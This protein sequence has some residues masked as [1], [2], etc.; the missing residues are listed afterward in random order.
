MGNVLEKAKQ[1][2]VIAL[3]RLG[4]SLRQIEAATGVRRE[5]AGGYLRSAGIAFRAPGGWGRKPPAKAATSVTT[6]SDG[7]K[8]ANEVITGFFPEVRLPEQVGKR[9]SGA[10]AAYREMIELELS[11]GRNAMGIYQDLVDRHGFR[12]GYQSVQR[13][14]RKLRG[15]VS[16]E[17]R[18]IIE[19]KLGEE[20]QVDYGSFGWVFA[21]LKSLHLVLP[22]VVAKYS[23]S[24]DLMGGKHL[25]LMTPHEFIETAPLYTHIEL[26]DF[27]PPDSITRMCSPCEKETTWNKVPKITEY[28]VET[29]PE[30]AFEVTGYTCALCRKNSFAVF[31][32][33]LDRTLEEKPTGNP[34][35]PYSSR[36]FYNAV[37]KIGQ[38]PPQ[39]I[40][41][42]AELD[43]RLGSAAGHYKKAL[44][45]SPL[46][47]RLNGAP[48]LHFISL[49]G[50]RCLGY[51]PDSFN[52][53]EPSHQ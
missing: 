42:P 36:H 51:P 25:N 15:A 18:V 52:K 23:S 39:E 3:G 7:S 41:I 4:W 2:Q 38:V 1:E 26:A 27:S 44:E 13:F 24:Y 28:K 46:K 49:L 6:G 8:P 9:P 30:I 21:A 37:R 20:C 19:T 43:D 29:S 50:R 31:Y 22:P 10:S 47:L 16:P 48:D 40:G 33:K 45:K 12:S 53:T 14:V 5:T 17:A 11:R 35:S 32:Q 34:A